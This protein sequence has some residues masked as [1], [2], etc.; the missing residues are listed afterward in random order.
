MASNDLI[1]DASAF[2]S[3]IVFQSGSKCYTTCDILE[4]IK[5]LHNSFSLI[6]L[7]IHTGNLVIME[8]SSEIKQKVIHVAKRTGDYTK[9]SSAD[10]SILALSLELN[11]PL[12][13]NDYAV[14][15]VGKLLDISIKNAG[16]AE[17]SNIRKWISTCKTCR[18]NF[19]PQIKVCEICGN[20][21]TRIYRTLKKNNV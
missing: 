1:L 16:I 21:L 12:V 19:R 15:N 13:T 17:I 18:K 4:E 2:Y 3:G 11:L 8:P 7:A 20:K 9:L 14:Q 6:N 10:I 5:H